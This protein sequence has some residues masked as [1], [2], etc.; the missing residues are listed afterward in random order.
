MGTARKKNT[1]DALKHFEHGL[2]EYG[3]FEFEYIFLHEYH[4]EFC[5]GCLTCLN[6]G[7]EKCPFKDDREKLLETLEWADGVVFASPNY[8][9]HVSGRMKNFLDRFAYFY[10]RPHFFGKVCTAIVSQGVFGGKKIRKYLES[11]GENFG[12][13][14]V[15]GACVTTYDPRTEKQN[16][17]MVKTMQKASKRFYKSLQKPRFPSPSLFRLMMFRIS[18]NMIKNIDPKYRD[19]QHFK[20]KGW[21]ESDYYYD[22]SFGI[23]KKIVGKFFDWMGRLIAKTQ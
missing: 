8:A 1:Y 5:N 10:H 15:K 2:K 9:F 19:H 18:R 13:R 21:F 17:K 7:E 20:E 3:E 22:V 12:F 23:G 14:P 4:L 16:K 6:Y 11:M